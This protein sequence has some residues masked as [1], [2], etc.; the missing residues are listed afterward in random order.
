MESDT[1]SLQGLYARTLPEMSDMYRE[2]RPENISPD[3]VV[4]DCR[5][6]IF[7]LRP[8]DRRFPV[9]K[10]PRVRRP[11]ACMVKGGRPSHMA[12]TALIRFIS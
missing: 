11:N 10:L 4:Q 1:A 5:P 6:R 9:L 2:Q 12:S 7:W 8:I 3:H